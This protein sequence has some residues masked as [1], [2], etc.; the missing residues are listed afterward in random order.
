MF[1]AEKCILIKVLTQD[2]RYAATKII[3]KIFNKPWTLRW[4]YYHL[5][6]HC[7]AVYN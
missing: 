4:P 2:K 5:Y 3:P 6:D 1:F 7:L